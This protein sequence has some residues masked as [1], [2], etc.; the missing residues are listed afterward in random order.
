MIYKVVLVS[1]AQQSE[2]VIHTHLPILFRFFP[3]IGH[4]RVLRSI[5]WEMLPA[6]F[7]VLASKLLYIQ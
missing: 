4:Y 3:H 5:P 2:S 6:T 1:A 7:L